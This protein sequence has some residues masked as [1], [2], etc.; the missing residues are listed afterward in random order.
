MNKLRKLKNDTELFLNKMK[1]INGNNSIYK[2]EELNYKNYFIQYLQK[3]NNNLGITDS[4]K[5]PKFISDNSNINNFIICE[6]DINQNQV[7]KQI[8][9]LNFMSSS[10]IPMIGFGEENKNEISQ[11]CNIMKMKL[12]TL[13]Y[14]LIIKKLILLLNINS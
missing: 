3:I 5:I 14:I 11:D 8:Q 12:K 1:S 13:I 10:L 6:Y 7:G 4:I 9:I 2:N